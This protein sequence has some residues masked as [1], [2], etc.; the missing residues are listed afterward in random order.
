M[1]KTTSQPTAPAPAWRTPR[2]LL[3]CGTLALA[4]A[5]SACSGSGKSPQQNGPASGSSA[6]AAG[7]ASESAPPT[8]QSPA[9]TRAPAVH[10]GGGFCSLVSADEAHTVLGVP[11][12]PGVSRTGAGPAGRAGSCLYK[13]TKPDPSVPSVVN[14]IVLGTKIPRSIYD[15]ELRH[16][17]TPLSG[18]GE[19]AFS[20][21]GVV[22]V[23]DHGLVLSL[24]IIK[25][26]RPVETAV[27][28]QLLRKA[29][30][31]AGHLG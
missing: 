17:R 4:L 30:G 22:T 23:F 24:E 25:G 11:V 15:Q 21:P 18:L 9:G 2:G 16:D 20:I 12:Q 7:V 3:S 6:G 8:S 1:T 5:L 31:R 10:A 27:I 26:G 19:D 14:V 29:L 28:T 13:V